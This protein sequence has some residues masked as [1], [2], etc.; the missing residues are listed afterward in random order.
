MWRHRQWTGRNGGW[1]DCAAASVTG[2][3]EL[4]AAAWA[5]DQPGSQCGGIGNGPA[6]IAKAEQA[7]IANRAT[8]RTLT[9]FIER[10]LILKL[11]L[12]CLAL[13]DFA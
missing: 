13:Q 12:G 8:S 1:V 9:R 10:V 11:P 5:T 3:Q 7:V 2:Q 4:H 6:G